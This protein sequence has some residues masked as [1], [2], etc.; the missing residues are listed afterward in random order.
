MS[1]HRICPTCGKER[2]PTSFREGSVDCFRCRALSV[3]VSP[4]SMPT[5]VNANLFAWKKE[6]RKLERDG[7]AYKRLRA[8]GHQPMKIDGSADLE[9][10][11][12]T[13]FEINS[14]MVGDP[15]QTAEAI[16]FFTDTFGRDPLTPATTPNPPDAA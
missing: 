13:R 9:A 8:E 14:G 3:S 15:K 12:S 7:E 10:R 2:P 1:L 11:A 5:R 6:E 4:S 16:S